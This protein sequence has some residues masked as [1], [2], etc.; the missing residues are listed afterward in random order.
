MATLLVLIFISFV[1]VGL[2]D[3]VLGTAWPAMYQE[4]GIPVSYA[5]YINMTV[6][7]GTI[8]SSM[9]SARMINR[10]GTGMVTFVSTVMTAVALLGFA[11][12]DHVW[13]FFLLSIPLGLGAG[14]I[15]CGLNNFVALHYTSRQMS[16]LHCSYGIGV[17]FSPWLMSLALSA[18]NDWRR[19]YLLVTG[20]QAV[21]ALVTFAALPLWKKMED[22]DAS[23]GEEQA[24]TLSMRQLLRLPYMPVYCLVFFGSCAVELTA[25]SWSSTFFV[26]AKGLA[27]DKAAQIA[28]LFYIGLTLGRFLSGVI[29]DKFSRIQVVWIASGLQLCAIV[30][31][32][33]P[34]S[35]TVAAAALLLIGMGVGPIFPNLTHLTPD[36]FGRDIS[37]SVMGIQYASSYVGILL[38]PSLFG[39]LAQKISVWVYPYFLLAMFL[40]YVVSLWWYEKRNRTVSA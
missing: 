15:D 36:R 32:M 28:M 39:I 38:M 6:S 16:F 30:L 2:P 37:Q 14:C 27:P 22:K 7:I 24:K 4:L 35:L 34:V 1:G 18:E 23:E 33:L 19:G 31:M 12:A 5:G 25:G 8:L 40:I 20:V 11:L 26:N 10:F 21:L 29:A 3:S 17:A 9:V 13:W